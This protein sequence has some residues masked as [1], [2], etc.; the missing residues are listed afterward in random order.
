M[1]TLKRH[2]LLWI[3]ALAALLRLPTLAVESLWY[4]ET[5]T[6]WLASL[7]L[8]NLI[9]A[10]QGDVH[11]PTWYLLEWLVVH[12]LG[13]NEFALRL[14]SALAGIA[15]VP[16]VWRLAQTTG[17]DR[18][19]QGAAALVTAVAP[20]AVYYSQEARAY[21]LLYLL[22]TLAT[23][24]LLERR[25]AWLVI[26]ATAALYLHNLACLYIAALAWLGLYHHRG[27]KGYYLAFTAIGLAWLP[28][29]IWGLIPQSSV[30]AAGGFWVRPPTY[31]TP[32]YILTAWLFT[33]KA[34]LLFAVTVPLLAL[35]ILGPFLFG[36]KSS[37]RPKIDLLALLLIPLG[38]AIIGSMLFNPILVARVIGSSAI[39]LYLLIAPRLRRAP[40][41]LLGCL[42]LVL[43][44][45]YA[46][47]WGTDRIGRYPWNFGHPPNVVIEPTDGIFHANLATYIVY[48]Y[49]LPD[50]DQ[51][52][53]QQANDLSQS[54]TDQTKIAMQMEQAQFEDVACSHQRWWVTF[55]E[56]PTT[57]P[58]ER[59]EIA[60]IVKQ[61]H[62]QQMATILKNELVN[63]RIYLL[64]D[65]CSQTVEVYP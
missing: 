4:D 46:T 5:F 7:P 62:G 58:A 2:P 41:P 13:P 31:G 40:A 10:A 16:A 39:V 11:P 32:V 15:L 37:S 61:Y 6:A 19:A 1:D 56:N 60:R 65:V 53:W 28:W 17:L 63:A 21:S 64:Q 47:Y 59:A 54:L 8:N 18:A 52:V 50:V 36:D 34:N 25:W 45:F 57:G 30:I 24:A 42:A 22:T 38:L 26:T 29:V 33:E 48:H 35:A 43:I 44:A 9:A 55:Y 3:T 27:T 51:A 23:I 12:A 20:F 14:I 49:Y